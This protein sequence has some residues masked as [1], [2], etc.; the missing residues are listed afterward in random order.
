MT[1]LPTTGVTFK[2]QG[3]AFLGGVLP[4]T[5]SRRVPAECLKDREIIMKT[6]LIVT[7]A[8]AATAALAVPPTPAPK[9][10]PPVSTPAPVPN[11]PPPVAGTPA[12]VPVTPVP[13]ASLQTTPTHPNP[14]SG[15]VNQNNQAG[16][17]LVPGNP[18]VVQPGGYYPN[19]Q[20]NVNQNVQSEL[21]QNV[22]PQFQQPIII[23]QPD[24][25]IDPQPNQ[26]VNP[27][28]NQP[29]ANQYYPNQNLPNGT[30]YG[31]V[32]TNGNGR[33][34]TWATNNVPN[35]PTNSSGWKYISPNKPSGS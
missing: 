12:A 22:Q 8:A 6:L 4:K 26:P 13:G 20:P 14:S 21:N 34:P 5:P 1:V 11:T 27:R 32:T 17:P 3:G 15:V 30:V 2:Q 35:Y 29:S 33:Q 25:P 31:G 19:G 28:P 18:Q 7:L 16:Q 9:P 10:R 23:P 24:Q